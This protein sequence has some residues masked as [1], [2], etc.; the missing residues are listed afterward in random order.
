MLR[1]R[2]GISCIGELEQDDIAKIR[3]SALQHSP[4]PS[5]HSPGVCL[6]LLC[7]AS[8]LSPNPNGQYII[9]V[10]NG[11]VRRMFYQNLYVVNMNGGD[12]NR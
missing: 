11:K 10:K 6:C 9:T 3:P 12:D 5:N 2:R 7:S 4:T 8:F 1:C